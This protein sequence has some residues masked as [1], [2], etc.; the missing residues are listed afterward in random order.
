MYE[1]SHRKFHIYKCEEMNVFTQSCIKE[2][3]SM[4]PQ[5]ITTTFLSFLQ[6]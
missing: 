5:Q 3:E 1:F 2:M 4:D 6:R